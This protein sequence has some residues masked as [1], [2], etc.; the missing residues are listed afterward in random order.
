MLKIDQ[1]EYLLICVEYT[2]QYFDF[3]QSILGR[4]NMILLLERVVKIKLIS[5]V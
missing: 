1:T 5:G 2:G 3:I 4:E